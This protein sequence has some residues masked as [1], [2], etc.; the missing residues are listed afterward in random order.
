MA[1]CFMLRDDWQ[2]ACTV[3]KW[4]INHDCLRL[5]EKVEYALEGSILLP[6]P[7]S[8]GCA[9]ASKHS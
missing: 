3:A 5:G 8:N 4:L 1:R 2:K 6:G 7:P 9:T